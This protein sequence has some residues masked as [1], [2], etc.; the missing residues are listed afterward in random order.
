M[1]ENR[2]HPVRRPK[3][4]K[5]VKKR[6]A[7]LTPLLVAGLIMVGAV[8]MGEPEPA[9][10]AQ[11]EPAEA[12]QVSGVDVQS[13]ITLSEIVHE[14]EDPLE[15]EKIEAAL[16]EQGYFLEEVPLEFTEQD[17]LHTA[18]QEAGI[19]YA[20]ALAVIEQETDFRNVMGDDGAS[21]GYMQ[22]QEK[23]HRERMERLGVT[24]LMDPFGNFQ[25]GCDFLAELMGKYPTQEALAAYNSGS[26][27]YNQY[28]YEVMDNYEKWKEL[29]GD[30]V[31][32][33][34]G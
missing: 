28:S 23:W 6:K 26:P 31:S 18:C 12:I 5:R 17:F 30:D 20:L 15:D 7:G 25:V 22:V 32:G 8:A 19:P 16:V 24:D 3:R 10:G 13:V 9:K 11:K 33:I 34:K 29:V 14:G 2:H 21:C 27:G 4:G 1:P